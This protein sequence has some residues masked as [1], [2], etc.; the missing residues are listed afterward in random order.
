M[1]KTL[2]AKGRERSTDILLVGSS[3][4]GR[5]GMMRPRLDVTRPGGFRAGAGL[6]TTAFA[7]RRMFTNVTFW[8]RENPL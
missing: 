2:A 3:F 8:T 5:I 1:L 6:H 7:A 4:I